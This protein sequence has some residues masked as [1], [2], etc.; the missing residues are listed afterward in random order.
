MFNRIKYCFFSLF[1]LCSLHTQ[2]I[3]QEI[4]VDS[5]Y[6][7]MNIDQKVGQLYSV[8]TA[9]RYGQAEIN[10]I[11]NIIDKYHIGGLIFSLGSI[12]DQ[13]IS[14]NIFQK[15]SNIPLLISMDAEWGLGMRLEDG[16]SFPYN[17]TL[18]AIRD[19]SLIFNVGQ[20]IGEHLKKM[21]VHLNFAPV[22]DV[23]T[24]PKNPIIGARSFGE[25]KFNVSKKSIKYIEGL[26]ESGVLAVGKHFP[27]HGDT[28]KDSHLTLP[29]LNYDSRRIDSIELYPFK[30]IIKN[31]VDGIMTAHLKVKSLDDKMITT[32]S[33]KI[34][35]D[36]LKVDLGFEGIVITDA[37]DMK[38]IVDYSKGNYPDV[39]ALIAGNDI[40]LMPTDL[41]K[42]ISEIKKAVLDGRVTE[43]RLED[44]VKK[45][46]KTKYKVGLNKYK[47]I[48]NNNIKDQLN[49]NEDY[50]LFEKLAEKSMTLIKNERNSIPLSLDK[51]LKVGLVNLGTE[52]SE[53]FHNYLNNFRIVEK[54]D[55][56]DLK[57]IK[58]AHKR[59]DKII[60][61]VH[62][63]DKS[64]F[65]DY[66][67]SKN[68]ISIINTLKKNNEIILVVFSNP[69]TL[70]DIN[71]NGFE[72]VL[73]AY[74]N[75]NIFQKKA[76]E[77]I[78][79]ANDID[80]VLPVTIGKNYEEGTSI[81]IKK[82]DI[83]SFDHPV[84][85]GVDMNKL[86]KIDSLINYAI[87]NK[88]T[89]GAQLLIAKNS[90][91]IYHNSFGYKTYEKKQEINNNSIYD[92]ASLTKI[93][94]SVPLLLKEFTHKN[95][96]L[97]TKLADW[98]PN[99]DLSDKKNLSVKQLFSHYSG[100]KSW[101]PFYKKTID[102]A[103]NKRIDKYFSETKSKD[104]PFQVLDKLFIKNYNDTI[105]NEIVKSELSDSLSYVYSDLPYFLLKFYLERTYKTSLDTQI[106]EFIYD[107]I[108]SS[109]LTYKPT[110]FFPKNSIVPTVIDDY[111]R[112][113]I[114]QGHVHDMGAAMMDGVSGHAGL[115]GNSLDVAKVLQLF[116]Q[117][118][119]YSKKLFFDEE[120]FNLFNI[121]HFEDEKVRRGIGFDKPELDPDDP[122]T[123]GC[124][125][126]SS[127]GHYG[128]TGSMAWVD[129]EKE[130]IY[131]F[132][133][134]RTY[135]DE[136]NN[137]L[138]E[139]NIR[140]EL[141]KIVH[142]AFE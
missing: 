52:N 66:K 93:L 14:H 49:T 72:S 121:R 23:N 89:P 64:P 58:D 108:G 87:K 113:D 90:N 61:S 127:F 123:C 44:A 114:V 126:E 48:P 135:P 83:L 128:F 62:K 138:S 120:N 65:E 97:N 5:V 88:M 103:T 122:N 6:S 74:Q 18:G 136:S 38:A 1:F 132:L 115:F 53:T 26:N 56:S 86:N 12:N 118:G 4:W 131:V 107:K 73:V 99:I 51:D 33:R 41:K 77:A 28:R 63:A 54:I 39:D 29:T 36:L 60:V 75:S 7:S 37:L 92:L 111:F 84:N 13:I 134:N 43:K 79:G 82:S 142:E 100:M 70:L 46:L 50:A 25:N 9:S 110:I 45:I 24:N 109:S 40:L 119:S 15:Q 101:I 3:Q 94:V 116:L 27:G 76:S 141:Q 17:I 31:G 59:Y 16:F 124:V 140:T 35:N 34:I 21:G 57:K 78:F 102:S 80:G 42:S 129:P 2:K 137:S 130:I 30:Q 69:Y 11:K 98:F 10:E 95:F 71:L 20:R 85:L 32:L 125:S 67:L 112:F 91:I 19:D 96:D 47:P 81:V 106:K 105:F 8:W 68:E 139:F 133:S 117:K 55:I 22:S 104:F